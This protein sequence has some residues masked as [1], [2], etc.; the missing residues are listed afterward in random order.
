[1]SWKVRFFQTQRGDYPVKEFIANQD[2]S[3]QVRIARHIRLLA[4]NG[5]Y[6]KPPYIKKLQT[7]LYEL[8]VSGKTAIRIFYTI[9]AG[10]YYLLH[11]LKKK[12]DKTPSK[13]LKTA[14]DRIEKLI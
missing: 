11:G 14:L 7:K 10:E 12:T 3:V 5:P 13:E 2:E 6:L 9:V 8:R 4:D 1:M